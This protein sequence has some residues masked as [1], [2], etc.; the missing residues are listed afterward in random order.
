MSVYGEILKKLTEEA[1]KILEN[2]KH[3]YHKI[4]DKTVK[5]HI[6]IMWNNRFITTAGD[7]RLIESQHIVDM[8]LSYKIYDHFGYDRIHRTFLHEMAHILD[9][10]ENGNRGHGD[11]FKKLCV[12]LG[13]S[14]NRRQAGVRYKSTAETEWLDIQSTAT[15]KYE[16]EC[17]ESFLRNRA[18]SKKQLY[19]LKCA[20]CGEYAIT[21]KKIRIN[22]G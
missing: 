14:M 13:G 22:N 6:K 18:F 8:R 4:G 16:C 20:S 3:L 2:R 1:E 12:E 7:V 9:R 19:G 17:G 5:R 11:S 21:F 10:L 15:W